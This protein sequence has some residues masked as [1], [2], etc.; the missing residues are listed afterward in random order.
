METGS[1]D[2]G[3]HGAKGKNNI[4]SNALPTVNMLRKAPEF[5][6][7]HKNFAKKTLEG[8]PALDSRFCPASQKWKMYFFSQDVLFFCLSASEEGRG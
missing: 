4:S 6:I 1:S 3:K 2:D 5:Q 7:V 8:I